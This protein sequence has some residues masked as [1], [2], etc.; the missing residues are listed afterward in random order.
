M[1]NLYLPVNNPL[2]SRLHPFLREPEQRGPLNQTEGWIIELAVSAPGKW[3]TILFL[4]LQ[5]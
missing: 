1:V 2:S 5:S 3:K 4:Q